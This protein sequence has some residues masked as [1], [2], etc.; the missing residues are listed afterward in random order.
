MGL[1]ERTLDTGLIL[2]E[3]GQDHAS[4][5]R[6]LKKRDRDLSLQGWPSQTHGCILWKVVRYAGPDRPLDTVAVWQSDRGEPFPLSSGILD[7]VDRLDKNSR[8][9][10]ADE[11]E[12][13]EG[14]RRER[15]KQNARDREALLSDY[16]TVMGPGHA[17]LLPRG[18][19]LRRARDKRR[20]RGEKC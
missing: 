11:D 19:S 3:Y 10:Y 1:V 13:N 7:L 9:H 5:E 17:G 16:K 8:H 18:Q 2:Q 6:E 15:E 14:R 4:L 12:R 20:N